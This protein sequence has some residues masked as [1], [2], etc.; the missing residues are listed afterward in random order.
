M[1]ALTLAAG[2]ALVYAAGLVTGW[3]LARRVTGYMLG[4]RP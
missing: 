3:H 4:G 2:I 1:T